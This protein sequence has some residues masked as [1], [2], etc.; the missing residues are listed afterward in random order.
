MLLTSGVL[1]AA[2]LAIVMNAALPRA[3][4]APA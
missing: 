4:K 2:L 3:A 1:P